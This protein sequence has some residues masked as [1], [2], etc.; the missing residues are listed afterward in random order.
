MP[1]ISI[2]IPVY[3][4]DK[5]I[6]TTIGSILSQSFSNWE[7][8]LVDD[9]SSD[10]TPAICKDVA[11]GDNRIIYIRQEKN[12]GPSKARNTGINQAKGE[13]IAFVDSDDTIDSTFLEKMLTVAVEH[14]S[15]IVW[16]NYK[17]ILGNDVIYRKHNLSCH[18][19]IPYETYIRLYFKNQEGL[20]S[21][22]TKLYRRSFLEQN[23]IRLNHN[24]VHGEDWEFNLNCFKCHPILVA[25]EDSLYNYI[26]Q[27]CS[28]VIAS[29]RALDYQTFV[30]SNK[31]L[32]E[33]AQNEG[34]A[35]DVIVMNSR[36]VYLVIA[37]LVSLKH[38]RVAD[39]KI[40]FNR[41]VNDEYFC[42]AI[43]SGNRI[44]NYLPMRYKFYFLLI[45][46]RLIDVAYV[47]M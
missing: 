39:K 17:E 4:A 24:R 30:I 5:Y 15:D 32:I 25:I 31:M 8:L 36:F 34:V 9:C 2:V 41:I 7:L 19:P 35:Y 6:K 26:R 11:R 37:L 38:S 33:L 23:N 10:N 44:V 18:T 3:N 47:V 27:N 43:K 42:N 40:E 29:Y 22:C 46:Y 21:M 45:K 12:G 13:Y 16:C 1:K 14:N 20:G 28:S